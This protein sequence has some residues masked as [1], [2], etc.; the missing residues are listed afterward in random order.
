MV[1]RKAKPEKEK[2]ARAHESDPYK[3]MGFM[4]GLEIHQRLATRHKLFCSCPTNVLDK[5]IKPEANIERYQRAV[6]GELGAVDKS[7]EFEQLRHRSFVYNIFNTNTCLVDCDEEPPHEMNR[8]ALG[9]SLSLA[10]AMGMRM[11][12][13]V[14]PMRKGVIDGSDP[15]AF[16]RTLVIGLDGSIKVNSKTIKVPLLSLEEESSG[17]GSSG[18]AS[19]VYNTDRL[20]IPLVEI[21]TDADIPDPKT[22][23]AVALYIGT[24]LRLT[25][26]V[27]RGIGSIRQDLNMSIRD[28]A[29]V[30]IKGVQ[31]L[32]FIDKFIENEVKRQQ[33]LIMIKKKLA[34]S[35]ASVGKAEN[36]TPIFLSTS[37]DVIKYHI[38]DGAVFAFAL[39]GFKGLLGFE[40]NPN[41]RLGTEISDYAKMAGVHGIIHSDEDLQKYRFTGE[42]IAALRR[43]L[44][45]SENDSF[46]I[47]AG[48]PE[49][50][51]R[52]SQLAIWRAEYALKGVPKE[53]R[54]AHDN[55][56]YTSKFLRPLPT[57][58][59]MYPETDIRPIF[60]TKE[61]RAA[62][63]EAEPNIEKER[64]YLKSKVKADAVVGQLMLSPRLPLFKAIVEKTKA[65]PE[66]VATV[67]L[68][69]MT[70]LRRSGVDVDSIDEGRIIEVF[71]YYADAKITKQAVQE[72]LALIPKENGELGAMLLKRGLLRLKG[73]DLKLL[74]EN[75]TK[76]N[77]GISKDDLRARIMAK[78]RLSVDGSELNSLLEG[79]GTHVH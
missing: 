76:E 4:C 68:Q 56:N 23:K 67:L 18:G 27:Q 5:S 11:I 62:A 44:R 54:M 58:S 33:N 12:D 41:R 74:V 22:A 43:Q 16:Q 9:I 77:K 1:A 79:K 15:S 73:A 19:V 61:M 46:I 48:K 28:G 69:K 60:I 36:V 30:E 6:A 50:V 37:V 26:K 63:A 66:F 71:R 39:K 3:A 40:I 25:G 45:I 2:D 72:V 70:E 13:E 55:E 47:I 51:E 78:Y 64:K 14:Q 34:A 32:D 53:T 21:D 59:R 35:N 7:A 29:R 57:G 8:E 38:K 65:D 20:G 42:E 31:E 75:Y 49:E 17:I 24:L 52:A 10:S